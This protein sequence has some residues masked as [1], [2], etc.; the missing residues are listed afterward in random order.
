VTINF[1]TEI[2]PR[3]RAQPFD[4]AL[5]YTHTKHAAAS[6]LVREELQRTAVRHGQSTHEVKR[7]S[8]ATHVI[9]RLGGSV[10]VTVEAKPDEPETIVRRLGDKVKNHVRTFQRRKG[11]R[12]YSVDVLEPRPRLHVHLVAA[13]P[14]GYLR[15]LIASLK[16]STIFGDRI[17]ARRVYDM[18][19]LTRY[20]CKF[21][22][23]QAHYAT[24]RAS[25]RVNGSHVMQG[26]RVRLSRELE[27][28]LLTEGCIRPFARTYARRLPKAPA[29]LAEIEVRYRDSLFDEPLPA[30]AAPPRLK[31]PP[32]R[33][34]K[35]PPPALP[36]VYPPS[37]ADML[38]GLGPTH[39]AIAE[40]VG[41]SRPQVTNIIIGRFGVSRPIARRVLEL[42][43]AA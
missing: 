18:P 22:T 37:V 2:E 41:L 25:R 9:E 26:D 27:R 10:F 8:E 17:K 3:L 16:A 19:R 34:E 29:F 35:I 39:E 23:P 31:T 28:D 6:F 20:L 36:L 4:A 5:V 43:R 33:R 1:N 15:S 7:L 21:A 40:R 30:L 38:A 12:A 42:A 32:R 11:G 14:R 24:G 13:A